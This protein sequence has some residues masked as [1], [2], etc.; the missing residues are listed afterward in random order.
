MMRITPAERVA[1]ET[2]MAKEARGRY[3]SPGAAVLA[4]AFALAAAW[5]AA[6][7]DDAHARLAGTYV[8]EAQSPE[9]IRTAIDAAVAKMNFVTRGVA[10]GRLR[11]ANVTHRRV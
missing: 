8:N 9:V 10:R 5:P 3:Q 11:K 2:V 6:A 1:A 7:Q 4:L